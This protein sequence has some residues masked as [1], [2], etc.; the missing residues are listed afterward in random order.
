MFCFSVRFDEK[1]FYFTD[2]FSSGAT[3]ITFNVIQLNLAIVQRASYQ[4]YIVELLHNDIDYMQIYSPG[5]CR[6]IPEMILVM[7]RTLCIMTCE[8]VC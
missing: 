1:L 2:A 3:D 5:N 4:H 8:V 6:F 7:V